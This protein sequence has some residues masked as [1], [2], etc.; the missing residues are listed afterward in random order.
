MSDR[1]LVHILNEDP[2]IADLDGMPAANATYFYFTNPRTRDGRPVAWN[3][4][5]NKGFLFP[6]A[7]IARV[8]F[9]VSDY[10]RQGIEFFVRD[11]NKS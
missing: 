3:T 2:F 11:E 4:G 1:V 8:E 7:R 5:P 10:E 9:M 6:I